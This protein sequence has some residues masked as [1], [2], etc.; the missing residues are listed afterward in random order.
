MGLLLSCYVRF[1]ILDELVVKV[2]TCHRLGLNDV[3]FFR[4]EV[5]VRELR[6]ELFEV[7]LS[8][9]LVCAGFVFVSARRISDGYGLP[10][11]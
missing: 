8:G 9:V 2:K 3:C 4:E 1:C 5:L 7:R 6:E 11:R 10:W